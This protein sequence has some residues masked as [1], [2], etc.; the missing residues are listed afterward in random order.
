[1]ASPAHIS[2]N[3]PAQEGQFNSD[4]V[5]QV[6][7]EKLVR[8]A[9]FKDGRYGNVQNCYL[10]N[11]PKEELV[12]EHVIQYQKQFK[13]AYDTDRELLLY[14]RNECGVYKFI[15]TTIRPQKMGYLDFYDYQKAVR[16]VSSLVQYEE[17]DPPDEYPTVIPA[18]TNVIKWQKGDCVDMSILLTSILLGSGYDAYVVL[19]TA[20][21][22]ITTKNE[23]YMEYEGMETE[24]LDGLY[25][26]E[27]KV[28]VTKKVSLLILLIDMCNK[29]ICSLA[30]FDFLVF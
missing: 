3:Q 24:G 17:L 28:Q 16:K 25:E 23:S 7:N 22:L 19:G 15:C 13:Y 9:K 2:A 21:R 29:A 26:D 8:C 20:H 1:M 12:L 14:P 5:N 11:S 18:P 4:E 6:I 10:E 30:S 27:S